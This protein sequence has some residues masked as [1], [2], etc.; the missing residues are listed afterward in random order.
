MAEEGAL[1]CRVGE[2]HVLGLVGD[3]GVDNGMQKEIKLLVN[4]DFKLGAEKY[5][6]WL[7]TRA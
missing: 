5:P 1:R 6:V 4:S 2:R 3:S 7:S